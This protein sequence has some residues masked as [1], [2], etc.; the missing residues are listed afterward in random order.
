MTHIFL[1]LNIP[2]SG[3]MSVMANLLLSTRRPVVNHPHYEDANIRNITM[4]VYEIY[5]RQIIIVKMF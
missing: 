5:S 4:R 1:N 3:P 2:F